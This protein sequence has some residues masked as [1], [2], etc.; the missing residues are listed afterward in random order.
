MPGEIAVL[1]PLPFIV[2]VI[3][4]LADMMMIVGKKVE[5][6]IARLAQRRAAW[7]SP[8]SGHPAAIG[9]RDYR[10]DQG[11]HPDSRGL[12][13]VVAGGFAHHPRSDGAEQL[14]GHGDMLY[15]PPGTGLP[16]RVHGAFVDDHEVTRVVDFCARLGHQ[17]IS[18]MCWL[19]RAGERQRQR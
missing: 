8:D 9:R 6:L 2:V 14:L 17:I 3:D 16:Q 11:Q 10:S 4:E 19:N 15:L 12:S 5:E 13:G 1:Q 18:T 7:H